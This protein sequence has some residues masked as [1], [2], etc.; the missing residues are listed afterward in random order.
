[1]LAA[2]LA[3]SFELDADEG[4]PSALAAQ[5]RIAAATDY[6]TDRA[7]IEAQPVCIAA[8]SW[9]A[10]VLADTLV[11]HYRRVGTKLHVGYFAKW[12][13]ERPWGP[14]AAHIWGA[15]ALLTDAFYSHFLF[16][17]PGIQRIMYG[18]GDVEG[19]RVVFDVLP[20]GRLDPI[21]ATADDCFHK[22]VELDR[23]D[24]RDAA[25][26]VVLMTEAWSH[27]LGSKGAVQAATRPGV[28]MTCYR[29]SQLV[30]LATP[31]AEAYR[32]GSIETPRRGRPAFHLPPA[33]TAVA[34]N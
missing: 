10:G 7:L 24:I 8:K 32:L 19:A 27:Q 30:P 13:T 18:P 14:G 6:D 23:G 17:F 21:R 33:E 22:G 29:G 25:G 5:P 16:V 28:T 34:Q 20:D 3:S 2:A 4:W 15:P 31:V 26:R 1:V 11:Y 9:S 12:S